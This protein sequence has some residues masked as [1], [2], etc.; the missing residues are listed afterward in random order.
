MGCRVIAE[1]GVNHNGDPARALAMVDAAADAGADVV[2]FQTF[3]AE[4]LASPAA[5]KAAYQRAATGENGSQL[6]MLKALELSHEAHVALRD[7]AAA[8]GIDFLSSAFDPASLRFLTDTLGLDTIKLGSGELTNGPLLVEAGRTR[9]WVVLSTGMATMEEIGEA[10]GALAFGYLRRTERPSRAALAR[11]G[12]SPEGRA[13]LAEKAVLL[14]CIS[15]YPAPV[16][17]CNLRAMQTMRTGFGL[18][19]GFSDHTPGIAVA[20]AAAAL[21]AHA[22]EKHFTLDRT[23]PGPDHAA[24]LEP[25]EL[26]AMI[27]GVR[28]ATAA[29]G[30]GKKRP[31]PAEADTAAAARKSLAAGGTVRRGDSFGEANLAVLRPGTGISPMDYWNWL[32]RRAERDYAAG[33]PLIP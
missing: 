33:E 32:G 12:A 2:K 25:A 28:A 21:G 7:R 24:S 19:V 16:E 5:P 15:A 9:V 20:I 13:W 31:M 10:L 11:A 18:P 6:A 8:R 1:A 23:L 30:D 26:A 29:L 3:V 22:I 14:H 4:A 17:E 27:A